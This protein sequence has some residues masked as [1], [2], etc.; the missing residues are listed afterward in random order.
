[1]RHLKPQVPIVMISAAVALPKEA[2]K[3]SD[4]FVAKGTSP[5]EMRD[6]LERVLHHAA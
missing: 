3:D 4:A 6:V 2:L 5:T 1:M